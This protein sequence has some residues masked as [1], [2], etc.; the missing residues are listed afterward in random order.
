M[1]HITQTLLHTINIIFTP[2]KWPFLQLKTPQNLINLRPKIIL[3]K[4]N[5][6][7]KLIRDT[8]APLA[9]ALISLIKL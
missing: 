2:L 7:Q 3:F 9:T 5:T 6:F 1:K 8:C 4:S